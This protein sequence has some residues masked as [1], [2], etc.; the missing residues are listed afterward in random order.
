M[1]T[2]DVVNECLGTMG[3]TPLNTLAEPH[4]FKGAALS[5]LTKLDKSCQAVGWWYNRETVTLQVSALDSKIYLPGDTIN[6]RP[7]NPRVAQRGRIL[8][9]TE[10][11]TPVFTEAQDAVLVRRVPFDEL[12]E[13]VSN[14]IAAKVVLRFQSVY[15]GDT[16]KTRELQNQLTMAYIELRADETRNTQ[17]NLVDSNARLQQ[18]KRKTIGARWVMRARR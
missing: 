11:S 10:N 12:P 15:D 4:A 17:A 13:S 8:Y 14:Y 2:L 16:A 6:V 18:I 5:L 3:E 1:Q 7:C 9:D